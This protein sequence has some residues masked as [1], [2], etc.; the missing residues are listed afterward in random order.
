MNR[1]SGPIKPAIEIDGSKLDC[2]SASLGFTI[3]YEHD[4]ADLVACIVFELG[5]PELEDFIA[6]R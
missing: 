4:S 5:I 3:I 2:D 1:K 6:A